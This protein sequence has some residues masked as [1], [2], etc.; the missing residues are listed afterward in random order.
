MSNKTKEEIEDEVLRLLRETI[1]NSITAERLGNILLDILNGM[2][3]DITQL[4]TKSVNDL[5]YYYTRSEIDNLAKEINTLISEI[6][7]FKIEVVNQLPTIGDVTTIYLLKTS[8]TEA[9]NLYTEYIYVKSKWEELGTQKLD[10]TGYATEE[11]VTDK[12]YT[13]NTGTVTR[14]AIK[15]NGVVKGVVTTSGEIDLGNVVVPVSG[16]GLSTNDYTTTEKNKLA[17]IQAG[18]EVN[19]QSNWTEPNE[20][21]AAFIKNKPKIP[22]VSDTYS[23]TSSDAMSGKAVASAISAES[24]YFIRTR[25]HAGATITDNNKW[26]CIATMEVPTSVTGT[27]SWT[28]IYSVVCRATHLEKLNGLLV[29]S[30]RV[31]SYKNVSHIS[32]SSD[33]KDFVGMFKITYNNSDSKFRL[34]IKE[35]EEWV[36]YNLKELHVYNDHFIPI[37]ENEQTFTSEP[38]KPSSGMIAT[39]VCYV[40]TDHMTNLFPDRPSSANLQKGDGNLYQFKA[41]SNMLVGK[42]NQDGHLLHFSWDCNHGYDS[43]LFIPNGADA[44]NERHPAIRGMSEGRWG[45]WRYL[46][47]VS[48][49]KNVICTEAEYKALAEKKSDTIYF[50]KS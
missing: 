29:Y 20:N 13:S 50:I 9:D 44:N 8:T 39:S 12:G 19:V 36:G 17:N 26:L 28:G 25:G 31:S 21:S 16:K 11:W 40:Q 49:I 1:P 42:P 33:N 47:F 23:S 4:V 30:L 27:M 43:Q 5:V 22:T 41:T 15:L 14:V 37:P 45:D 38:I 6:P 24:P 10:L 46:A 2:P 7:K 34:Y 35:D 3:D 18:A 48:D 32:L